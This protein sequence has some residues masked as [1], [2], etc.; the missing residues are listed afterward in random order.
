MPFDP[1][2]AAQRLAAN[3][4]ADSQHFLAEAAIRTDAAQDNVAAGLV[5]VDGEHTSVGPQIER[6]RRSPDDDPFQRPRVRGLGNIEHRHVRGRR[7]ADEDVRHL[8]LRGRARAAGLERRRQNAHHGR[9]Q[10]RRVAQSPSLAPRL[11][12]Q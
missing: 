3:V 9:R 6:V 4:D 8:F 10:Y 5:R 11:P 7:Q 2:D 1:A 12:L